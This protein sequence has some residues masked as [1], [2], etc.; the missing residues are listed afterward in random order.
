MKLSDNAMEVLNYR[1]LRDG[2]SPEDMFTRVAMVAASSEGRDANSWRDKFKTMLM[3]LDFVPNTPCLINAGRGNQLSACF[4]LGIDDDISSIFNTLKHTALIHKSGGGT[5]FDFSKLRPSGWKVDKTSGTASGP[6]SFMRVYNAATREMKQGGVRR[7]ANMA[8]LRCDHPDIMDF[9]TCKNKEGDLANFNISV[10]ITDEFMT[11]LRDG[12]PFRLRFNGEAVESVLAEDIW[13]A[14]MIGAHKNGEPGVIFIDRVNELNPLKDIETLASTNPCGEQPLPRNGSCNLGHI[15]LTNFWDASR[16]EMSYVELYETIKLAVRFLDDNIDATTYPLRSIEYEAKRTRRIGLGIMGLADLFLMAGLRYG[17]SA[18]RKFTKH[19]MSKIYSYADRA[20]IKLGEERGFYEACTKETPQRRNGVILTVA[21]TGSCSIIANVSSGCEPIFA[22]SFQKKCIDGF[23][24]ID[25]PLAA[26]YFQHGEHLPAHFVTAADV[27]VTQHVK[28]QAVIQQYIDS[29]ISKTINAP[30]DCSRSEVNDA[31]RLAY[32][33]GCKSLTF[34]REGSRTYEAQVKEHS[35]GFNTDG[36][37]PFLS[38]VD[39]VATITT[40]HHEVYHLTEDED[41]APFITKR[42]ERLSGFTRKINTGRGKLYVTI[43]EDETGRPIELFAKIG[44]SGREDFAYTEALG[45][46]ITLGLRWGV[47][48]EVFYKHFTGI[49][50]YDTVWAHNK[51]VTSV[52][53]AIA[54][55]MDREYLL[56][57]RPIPDPPVVSTIGV[58]SDPKRTHDDCPECGAF[59]TFEEGCEKCQACGYSK[60]G[61]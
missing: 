46:A 30:N 1:Y 26:S 40:S 7:G 45:R 20:S 12:L 50:G 35:A 3:N 28:M 55:I 41:V 57:N 14:I 22:Y 6:V 25:H 43:N 53:D 52:P 33:K 49:I 29:G 56:A 23:I 54:T 11:A 36:N 8:V 2:E 24:T 39:G 47:P 44:K 59:V 42:P 31:F 34:Y 16:Q 32:E 13:D 18:S 37:K 27:T 58:L 38:D 17:S 19:L 21:P 9:I 51:L 5:G 4:V 60:C 10:A 61:G 48:I 15:N